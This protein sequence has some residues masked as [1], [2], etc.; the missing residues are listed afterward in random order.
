VTSRPGTLAAFASRDFRLLWSGQTISFVGD[1]AFVVVGYSRRL[2]MIASD[3]ARASTV[4]GVGGAI[5]T[6]LRFVPLTW[7]KVR[8]VQ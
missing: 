8:N 2:L 7:R 3:I 6:L 1:A 4:V 5:G